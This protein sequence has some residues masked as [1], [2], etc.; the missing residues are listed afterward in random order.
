MIQ[1][2]PIAKRMIEVERLAEEPSEI[3]RMVGTV[4]FNGIMI[5]DGMGF[6]C[7]YVGNKHYMCGLFCL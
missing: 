3:A 4:F 2:G 1:A 6:K 5:W 7:L